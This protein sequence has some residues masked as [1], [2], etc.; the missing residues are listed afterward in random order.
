MGSYVDWISSRKHLYLLAKLQDVMK[1][2]IT[3]LTPNTCHCCTI[4]VSVMEKI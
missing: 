4:T 2:V 3:I 1:T